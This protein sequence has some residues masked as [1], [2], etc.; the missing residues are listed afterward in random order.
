[1]DR[2]MQSGNALEINRESSRRENDGSSRGFIVIQLTGRERANWRGVDPAGRLHAGRWR[3]L[4]LIIEFNGPKRALRG[5]LLTGT[6]KVGKARLCEILAR[7]HTHT[8]STAGRLLANSPLWSSQI[9]NHIASPVLHGTFEPLCIAVAF[10]I[11]CFLVLRCTVQ[12][13]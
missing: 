5:V 8:H 10:I 11:A 6:K 2:R 12:F 1:M 13:P 4:Q 7:L 3:S 9:D